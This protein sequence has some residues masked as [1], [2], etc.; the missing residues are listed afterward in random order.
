[1]AE[2]YGDIDE[3]QI[4]SGLS[5]QELEQLRQLQHQRQQQ[6][7]RYEQE[8]LQRKHKQQQIIE[9]Q[10]RQ[11]QLQQQQQQQHPQ[12]Q[13]YHQQQQQRQQL[14]DTL[15]PNHLRNQAYH[16]LGYSIDEGDEEQQFL[17]PEREFQ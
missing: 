15:H 8:Q 3:D 1:M 4:L 14:P 12:Q 2:P 5:A 10:I 6:Q 16:Q 17:P 11:Q 9:H 13:Q 7:Q